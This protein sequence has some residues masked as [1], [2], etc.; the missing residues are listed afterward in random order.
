MT[1]AGAK[2]VT[3]KQVDAAAL[4]GEGGVEAGAFDAVIGRQ[5][6]MFVDRAKTFAGVLRALRPGGKL[7][8]CVWGP[9]EDNEFHGGTIEV[10]RGKMPGGVWGEDVP[11]MARAFAINE[12]G[13]W[14]RW[15][16]EAGFVEVKETEVRGERRYAS[17]A[18]AYR[19]PMRG[20][21]DPRRA[22][23]GAAGGAGNRRRR[24]GRRWSGCAKSGEGCSRRCISSS[25][26]GRRA[27]RG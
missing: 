9:I 4:E 18:E 14:V 22:G 2:N 24:S 19:A 12:R 15:L 21:A 11:Q 25:R 27:E 7:G 8:A 6:L 3:V 17:P 13:I 26:G 23:G 5:V 20:V 10:A 16:K 1:A